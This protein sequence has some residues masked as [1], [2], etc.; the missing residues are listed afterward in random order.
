MILGIQLPV[1]F[2]HRAEQ[3]EA[4]EGKTREEYLDAMWS[5]RNAE[6]YARHGF[7]AAKG[8]W[9]IRRADEL[10]FPSVAISF[11]ARARG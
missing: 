10:P 8:D 6:Y 2:T 5:A 3:M 9:P 7:P 11:K 1:S 4:H